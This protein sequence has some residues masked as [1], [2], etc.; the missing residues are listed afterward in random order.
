MIEGGLRWQINKEETTRREGV[1][2]VTIFRGD[3]E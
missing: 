1:R 2:G 3:R